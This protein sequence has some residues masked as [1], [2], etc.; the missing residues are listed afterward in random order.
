MSPIVIVFMLFA[1]GLAFG[2]AWGRR[3]WRATCVTTLMVPAAHVVKHVAGMPDTLQPNTYFS[4]LM[5]AAFTLAVALIGTAIGIAAGRALH[6]R[7]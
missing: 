6:G 1:A 4:I 5:L 2:V 3:A 7:R